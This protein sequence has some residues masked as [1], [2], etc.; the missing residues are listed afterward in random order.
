MHSGVVDNECTVTS[1]LANGQQVKRPCHN[2]GITTPEFV[3]NAPSYGRFESCTGALAPEH[4]PA[5]LCLCVPAASSA[6]SALT[7]RL[8]RLICRVISG[9]APQ[10]GSEEVVER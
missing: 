2:E 7:R 6:G 5:M 10:Q 1:I 9:P 4:S 8:D 3:S